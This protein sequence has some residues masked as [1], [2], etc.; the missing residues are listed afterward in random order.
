MCE[1][2]APGD[3]MG[4][5]YQTLNQ[6]RGNIIE[7]IQLDSSLS[8]IKA[9]LPVAASYGF[10]EDLRGNTQGKAFPQCIFSHWENISGVPYEDAK[11]TNL[12]MDIR[13]RKGLKEELPDH[14][15]LL[16]KL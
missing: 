8:I 12:V 10:T 4:G 16:D 5:I 15:D 11:G 14:K 7:E 9:H 2:T 1:I 3:A 13:K 6:R